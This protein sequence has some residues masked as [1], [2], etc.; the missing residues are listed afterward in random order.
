MQCWILPKHFE[1]VCFH[2][3]WSHYARLSIC[4][5]MGR[6]DIC[7]AYSNRGLFYRPE[8][9]PKTV[10]CISCVM[11]CEILSCSES[12]KRMEKTDQCKAFCTF[13]CVHGRYYIKLFHTG[14]D[15]HNGILMS[16]L[17]LVAETITK[18]I[19]VN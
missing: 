10:Y 13:A 5:W 4:A 16:L 17:L 19:H 12:A 18:H 2:L 14:A 7:V 8:L 6:N 3:A 9:N 11:V 1:M 15:R